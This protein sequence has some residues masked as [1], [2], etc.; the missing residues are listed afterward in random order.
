MVRRI[1]KAEGVEI[2]ADKIRKKPLN[3]ESGNHEGQNRKAEKSVTIEVTVPSS[4]EGASETH[5]SKGRIFKTDK[6][7]INAKR[8]FGP[9]PSSKYGRPQSKMRAE[10]DVSVGFDDPELKSRRFRRSSQ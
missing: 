2:H 3:M 10:Q 6:A 4:K 5:P 9:W 1:V 7:D 8:I